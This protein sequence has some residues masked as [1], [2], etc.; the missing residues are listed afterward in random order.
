MTLNATWQSTAPADTEQ[1]GYVDSIDR[2][3]D[4]EILVTGWAMADA[5]DPDN[6]LVLVAGTPLRVLSATAMFR[7]DVVNR[8]GDARLLRSGFQVKIAPGE[9]GDALDSL[10]VFS[11]SRQYGNRELH[12]PAH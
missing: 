10:Q 6:R 12:L 2:L 4:G 5:A 11:A 8:F 9:I 3:A 7:P 1:G